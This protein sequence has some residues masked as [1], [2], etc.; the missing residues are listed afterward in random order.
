M[1]AILPAEV[2][3]DGEAPPAILPACDHS[4]GSEKL[5]LKSLALQQQL[6]PV[7]DITLDCEDGAQV[8]REAEHAELVASFIGGEH[9]RFGRIGVRI[10][11][12]HHPHWRDDVRMILRAAMRAPAF[13]TLPMIRAVGDAA[14]MT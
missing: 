10:H 8:G 9:D 4:A 1:R 14:D 5:M 11:D 6:G 3:F 13:S 12:F 2:L 7:F